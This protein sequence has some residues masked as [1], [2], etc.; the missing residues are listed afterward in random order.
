MANL[1]IIRK[2]KNTLTE[3]RWDLKSYRFTSA[4][5]CPVDKSELQT[6]TGAQIACKYHPLTVMTSA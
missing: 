1:E 6:E 4:A 3:L 2:V 5:D